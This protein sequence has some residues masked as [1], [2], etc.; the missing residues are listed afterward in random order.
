MKIKLTFIFLIII[1]SFSCK[2]DRLPSK[3]RGNWELTRID[4]IDNNESENTGDWSKLIINFDGET[5]TYDYKKGIRYTE[6]EF[7]AH[8]QVLYNL[9]LEI[10]KNILVKCSKTD[11]ETGITSDT[12]FTATLEEG[13]FDYSLAGGGTYDYKITF[14]Q[15]NYYIHNVLYVIKDDIKNDE[16]ILRDDYSFPVTVSSRD[17]K[18]IFHEN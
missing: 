3:L 9:K 18:Y 11:I 14:G 10:D 12:S 5:L 2:K 13:D 15:N 17:I 16:L 8:K 4:A 6:V 1:F 7:S